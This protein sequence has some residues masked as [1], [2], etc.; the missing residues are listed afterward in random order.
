MKGTRVSNACC[1]WRLVCWAALNAGGSKSR[2]ICLLRHIF[3][4]E[5][6]KL[7]EPYAYSG[8]LLG[9]KSPM[10]VVGRCEVSW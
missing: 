8:D 10:A 4:F 6:G 9:A 2:P 7:G 5:K 3:F 1:D